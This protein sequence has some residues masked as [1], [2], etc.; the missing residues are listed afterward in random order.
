[1]KTER[2]FIKII[3]ILKILEKANS[4]IKTARGAQL[5]PFS[6]LLIFT[7]HINIGASKDH[8][9]LKVCNSTTA[10]STDAHGAL[11]RGR[12]GVGGVSRVLEGYT[13]RFLS[14]TTTP[15]HLLLSL[16]M[17]SVCF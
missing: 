4:D 3:I 12:G 8:A 9:S 5:N 15:F 11:L 1:M 13:S 16:L 7:F 6:R 17:H 14:Y 2:C 10:G